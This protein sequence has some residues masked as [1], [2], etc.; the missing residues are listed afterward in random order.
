MKQYDDYRNLITLQLI[1][2]QYD[3]RKSNTRKEETVQN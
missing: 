3:K 2:N 1:K